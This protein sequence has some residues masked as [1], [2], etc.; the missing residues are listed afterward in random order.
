[1]WSFGYK[2]LITTIVNTI[3]QNFLSFIFGRLFKPQAVGNFTQAYKWNNNASSFISGTIA[4]VAQ[5]VLASIRE[6][7]EREKNVFRKMLRFTAFLSFPAMFGLA[8]VANEFIITLISAK[9]IDSVPLLQILCIGG[10]F[11]PFLT[12]YQNLAI[13]QG[14]SD[15]YM[16]CTISQVVALILIIL[17]THSYGITAMVAAYSAFNI[18]WLLVWQY[19]AHRLIKVSLTEVCK[20]ILPFM[21]SAAAVMVVD[22]FATLFLSRY[23]V[24]LLLARILLAAILYFAIMKIAHVQIMDECIQFAKRKFKKS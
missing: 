7:S 16:W 5:P 20:D 14:R 13:S 9:W 6:D 11:L 10:A 15:I 21:L 22:H 12:L 8:L 17:A 4:Q 24:I 1:M 2:I 19:F 3:S 23:M 18:L